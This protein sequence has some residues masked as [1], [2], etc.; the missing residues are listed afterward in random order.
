MGYFR[1]MSERL[2]MNSVGAGAISCVRSRYRARFARGGT[3][4]CLAIFAIVAFALAG[5]GGPSGAGGGDAAPGGAG[6]P[7][8]GGGPGG[9]PT[10]VGLGDVTKADLPV[11]VLALGTVTPLATV[12]VHSRVDGQIM[13][14]NFREGQMIREGDLL[15]E[16]D[17]RP[18]DVQYAQAQGQLDRDEALLQIAKL[19]LERYRLLYSQDSIAKQLLDSQEGLVHQDEGTVQADRANVA[20]ARLQQTYA[21]VTAPVSGRV[22]LRQVDVGNVVHAADANGIVVI[23]QLQPITVVG[24]IPEDRLQD[25]LKRLAEHAPIPVEAFDR[26]NTTK[27]ATGTLLTI[28][29]QI[30]V[31]TGTV[32]VK[33]QFGNEDLALFPNQFVNM[34]VRY[35]TLKDATVVPTSAVQ[36]GPDGP[37]LYV[38]NDDFTVSLHKTTVVSAVGERTAI[39]DGATPGQKVVI[40][41]IDRLKDGAK[42]KLADAAPAAKPAGEKGKKKWSGQKPAS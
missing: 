33:A 25:L 4:G 13:R 36:Q 5:C 37:Y 34:K 18:F 7:G 16:I 42:I 8:R 19:D 24:T 32:K 29:N 31:T 38:V 21:R 1:S 2:P 12:T 6:R 23:T 30:D 27:L 41:G 11:S 20:S 28:D 10:V 22:G 15:A 9:G 14:V 40:D 26:T 3:C 39:A 35:G 17:P